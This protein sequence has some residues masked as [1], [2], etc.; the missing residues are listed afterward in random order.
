MR[1][2]TGRESKRINGVG[3]SVQGN[4][5]NFYNN[6]SKI[7]TVPRKENFINREGLPVTSPE[8]GNQSKG[9]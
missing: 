1:P 4:W 3:G 6:K 9:K 2:P 5:R 7:Y 8:L